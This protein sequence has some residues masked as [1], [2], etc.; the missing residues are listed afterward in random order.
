MTRDGAIS[1]NLVT[2]ETSHIS[3]RPPEQD[4]SPSGDSAALAKNAVHRLDDRRIHKSEKKKRRN[5]RRTYREGRAAEDRPSS[6]L[7]FSEEERADPSLKKYM[8]R[9]DKAA[10]RLD[11][12]KA[13]IPKKRILGTE[14]VFDEETG[15][16]R[17]KL[18]FRETDKP[19]SFHTAQNPLN[20]S[21]RRSAMPPTR[22]CGRWSRKMWVWNPV[23]WWNAARRKRWAMG[24]GNFKTGVRTVS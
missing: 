5:R 3:D 24:T 17:T 20:R 18:V 11:A 23:I 12:A 6:R 13:A 21:C 10:D 15:T 16:G 9:S 7:Q 14:R 19:A 22:K 2:G 4:Y 1:V 8:D